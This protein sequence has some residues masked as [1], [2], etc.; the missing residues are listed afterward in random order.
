MIEQPDKE[1]ALRQEVY[2]E[3]FETWRYEVDSY[4]QRNNYFSAFETAAIAGCWY[5]VEHSHPWIASAFSLLG[6]ASAL[7]WLLTSIAVHK[8]VQYWWGA[9]QQAEHSLSLGTQ[10]LNFATKHPGSGML[11][12]P[13]ILVQM[14]PCLFIV[15]WL[16]V[17]VF[18]LHTLCT[19]VGGTL[20]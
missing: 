17:L 9:I 12:R 4:W 7:I 19:C 3:A 20:N 6:G 2:K 8:Y 14:V 1:L 18:S 16:V 15:A 13:S 5:I 11:A 10:K